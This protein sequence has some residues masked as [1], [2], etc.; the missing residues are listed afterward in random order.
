MKVSIAESLGCVA[1]IA[2]ALAGLTSH[3]A[4]A[5]SSTGL[6]FAIIVACTVS[7]LVASGPHRAFAVGFLVPVVLYWAMVLMISDFELGMRSG[8]LP[9]SQLFQS[10]LGPQG[11]NYAQV[12][13][14]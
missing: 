6:S 9:T 1:F 8:W 2:L 12:I 7:A 5:W 10:L 14:R 4:V 13:A 11:R 3:A